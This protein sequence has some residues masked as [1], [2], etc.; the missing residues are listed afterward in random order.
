MSGVIPN[1]KFTKLMD[2][3]MKKDINAVDVAVN[4]LFLEGY[5]MVNQVIS[6]HDYIINLELSSEKKSNIGGP[7][8][9]AGHGGHIINK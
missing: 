1:E 8:H 9:R 2:N 3:V 5:S 7:P 4:G 6:F